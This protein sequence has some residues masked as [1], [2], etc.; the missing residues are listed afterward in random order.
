MALIEWN[1]LSADLKTYGLLTGSLNI[2]GS[3]NLDGD[4]L[5]AVAEI[6]DIGSTSLPFRDLYLTTGSLKFVKGGVVQ[7]TVT[8]VKEG[9]QVGNIKIT[10]GSIDIVNNAGTTISTVAQASSSAG[11]VTGTEVDPIVFSPTGSFVATTND[12]QITGSAIIT[13]EVTA[14]SGIR[15]V[16]DSVVAGDLQV[17]D[18]L[19]VSQYISHKGDANTRF[20]FTD[21]RVQLEAGGIN[22]FGAH[23]KD[24][25]PHLFTINNGGNH[26]DFQIKDN[27]GDT[28][29]RTDADSD[30]VLFPDAVKISGSAASTGS[31]GEL[32]VDS[33]IT[34]GGNLTIQGT[35][36]TI[37]TTNLTIKDKF[38]VFASGSTSAVDGGIIISKQADG[39][40]FALGY[41][42]GT[43]RWGLDNDLAIG[44]TDI[45]PD[46]YLGLVTYSTSAPS[47]APTYGGASTGYGAIHVKSDTGD[48]YIYS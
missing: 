34:A 33:N 4:L 15:A 19:I 36:T 2:S 6:H 47:T 48:I 44:A 1:Q 11:D 3:V 5:P 45:S 7:A 38:A 40:G 41:D 24:A 29:F 18:D 23:K 12:I 30:N 25:T 14:S 8:A 27:D 28:L 22:F 21:D 39:A 46:S 9:I 17:N 35:T 43:S 31:F 13:S 32:I 20:N 10:T 26:I 42:S 37:D 16:G